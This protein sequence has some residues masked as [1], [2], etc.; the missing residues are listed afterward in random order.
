MAKYLCVGGGPRC[1]TRL[2][3]WCLG[4]H[5]AVSMTW[6]ETMLPL[7]I[8][9]AAAG[10]EEFL[11]TVDGQARGATAD[12]ARA[13]LAGL[14]EHAPEGLAYIGDKAPAYSLCWREVRQVAPD[15]RFVFIERDVHA[16][17]LSALRFPWSP[18]TIEE[19]EGLVQ[20]HLD[21][22]RQCEGALW[23]RLERLNVNPERELAPVLAGL[24]LDPALMPWASVMAQIL[25][26]DHLN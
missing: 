21:G 17:A 7:R 5:P 10:C 11:Q 25:S 16:A 20:M 8:M 12:M 22:A 18:D 6:N 14:C 4:Q 9:Q 2:L 1:G 23:V 3:A 26:P 15:A 19:A 24:G 13:M